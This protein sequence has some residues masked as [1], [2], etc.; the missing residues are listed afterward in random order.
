MD[1]GAAAEDDVLGA[2]ELGAAG[3]FVAGV[4]FDVVASGLG[5]GG[6]GGIGVVGVGVGRA[7]FGQ[8]NCLE[9]GDSMSRSVRKSVLS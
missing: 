7:G 8:C 6:L 3:D 5:G 2:V 4:G 9:N 1:G